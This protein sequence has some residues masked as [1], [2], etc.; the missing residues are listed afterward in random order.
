MASSSSRRA[1]RQPPCQLKAVAKRL[2]HDRTPPLRW[3]RRAVAV[4][5]NCDGAVLT[6]TAIINHTLGQLLDLAGSAKEVVLLGRSTPMAPRSFAETP[7]TLLARVQ[8][9]DAEQMLSLVSEGGST[10]QSRSAVRKLCARVAPCHDPRFTAEASTPCP[11]VLEV[12]G[13]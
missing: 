4:L 11:P 3:P 12:E 13:P 10:R 6:G 8:V 5:P 2:F 1:I 9:A 7:V